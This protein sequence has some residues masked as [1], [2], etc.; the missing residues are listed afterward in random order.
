MVVLKWRILLIS[1]CYVCIGLEVV[2]GLETSTNL[3][4]YCN[5]HG[6]LEYIT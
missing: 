4:Y 3:S 5:Y 6:L 1:L 2:Y